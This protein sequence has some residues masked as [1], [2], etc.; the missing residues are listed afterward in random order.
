[1]TYSK[2]NWY[3]KLYISLWQ[4]RCNP[5]YS[6]SVSN[7]H[8]SI[9]RYLWYA[10]SSLS[11]PWLI[12]VWQTKFI[13]YCWMLLNS[14]KSQEITQ[15]QNTTLKCFLKMAKHELAPGRWLMKG[16]ETWPHGWKYPTPPCALAKILPET[17][18]RAY[19]SQIENDS[20][21]TNIHLLHSQQIF[22]VLLCIRTGNPR[23]PPL[24]SGQNPLAITHRL[25]CRP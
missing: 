3:N 7:A 6:G 9:R 24:G 5:E 1:M 22:F 23:V 15:V 10:E 4:Y 12:C 8:H 2:G 17:T 19:F 16:D 13:Q 20:P 11:T 14:K 25:L 18:V 21:T